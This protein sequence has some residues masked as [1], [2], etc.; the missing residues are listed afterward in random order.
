M[1]E[2]LNITDTF[3]DYHHNISDKQNHDKTDRFCRNF[4]RSDHRQ[5][6][7]NTPIKTVS[8]EDARVLL[9]G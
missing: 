8:S 9:F 6:Q 3:T 2:T 1:E 4:R 7:C 5:M